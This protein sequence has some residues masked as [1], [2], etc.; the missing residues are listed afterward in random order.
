MVT[1][2]IGFKQ[3]GETKRSTGLGVGVVRLEALSLRSPGTNGNKSW[4]PVGFESKGE[5]RGPWV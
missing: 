4:L 5:V 1:P 2:S 3:D